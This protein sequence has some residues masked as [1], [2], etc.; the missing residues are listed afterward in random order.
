MSYKAE[1]VRILIASPGDCNE[2]RELARKVIYEWN[3]TNAYNK[4]IIILPVMWEY[5]STPM[6][7]TYAQEIINQQLTYH[8]DIAIAFFST[9]VGSPTERYNSGTIEEIETALDSD[10]IVSLYFSNRKVNINDINPLFLLELGEIKEKYSQKGLIYEFDTLP[11]LK[12]DLLRHLSSLI[13]NLKVKQFTSLEINPTENMIQ[14]AWTKENTFD[15]DAESCKHIPLSQ[16]ERDVLMDIHRRNGIDLIGLLGKYDERIIR[17]LRSN[18]MIEIYNGI[19]Q[20]MDK[21]VT[22]FIRRYC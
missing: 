17:R 11:N 6:Q 13:D 22:E 12:N 18:G 8:C 4:K 3:S 2:E 21:E 9:R 15:C 10:K 16:V 5:D 19:V 1:V 20:P 14:V 7:G